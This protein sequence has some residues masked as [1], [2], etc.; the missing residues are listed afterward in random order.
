MTTNNVQVALI[1]YGT[2]EKI[3][4]VF[5]TGHIPAVGDFFIDDDHV[6]N[7]WKDKMYLVKAVTHFH[8]NLVAAH[9]DKYDVDAENRK[10]KN[11]VQHWEE[12]KERWKVDGSEKSEEN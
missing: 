4:D 2:N 11:A 1:R 6:D 12:M 10:W 3:K 7:D 8:N 5:M 9:V